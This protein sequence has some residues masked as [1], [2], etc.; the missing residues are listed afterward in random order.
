MSTVF[1]RA[2]ALG[3]YAHRNSKRKYS[4]A[5]YMLHPI[6][7]MEILQDAGITDEDILA[8]ALL[9]DTIEDEDLTQSCIEIICNLR[10]AKLV[11]EV[12]DVSI[13]PQHKHKN[14]KE[15]KALD[16]THLA[17]SSVEGA[18]IKLA[19]LIHNTDDILYHD[20]NF[21][22]VYMREKKAALEVLAH[23]NPDLYAQAMQ[24]ISEY[25]KVNT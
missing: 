25:Y 23:G 13:Q 4:G 12:T 14:R 20:K 8:A 6:A 11:L 3:T 24:R 19:D 15:R 2:L 22:V 5:P 1:E 16:R 21:A 9:H 10:V 17:M 18:T 7:V